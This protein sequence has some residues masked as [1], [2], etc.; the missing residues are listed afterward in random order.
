MYTLVLE[1]EAKLSV[2]KWDERQPKFQ[3]FFGPGIVAKI[4]MTDKGADVLLIADGTG[5]GRTGKEK[6]DVLVPLLPGLK[7]RQ[8]D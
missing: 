6:K 4:Q 2:E 3:G 1:F 8:Q 7:P 5:T